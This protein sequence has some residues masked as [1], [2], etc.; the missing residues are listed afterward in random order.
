MLAR[1]T[2][3]PAPPRRINQSVRALLN[4]SP[5]AMYVLSRE[6][7]FGELRLV[8]VNRR[9]AAITGHS[10]QE[11]KAPNWWQR[12][13]HPTDLA[14]VLANLWKLA[15]GEELEMS[16]RFL[17]RDGHFIRVHDRLVGRRQPGGGLELLGAWVDVTDCVAGD[18]AIQPAT[19]ALGHSLC[20]EVFE[21]YPDACVILDGQGRVLEWTH[22]AETLFGVSADQGLGRA[23]D[24]LMQPRGLP[25][26]PTDA[27]ELFLSAAAKRPGGHR[28]RFTIQYQDGTELPV[29]VLVMSVGMD[30]QGRLACFIRDISGQLLNEARMLQAQKLEAIGQ[31]TGGLAHD[32]N[33]ILG[34]VIASLE[35]LSLPYTP[36]EKQQLVAGALSAAGRGVEVIKALLAVARRQTLEPRDVDVNS[37]LWELEPLIRQTVG[38]SIQIKLAPVAMDA[39]AHIDPG[40]FGNAILNLVINARDAMPTGGTLYIY[41][42]RFDLLDNRDNAPEL[43]LGEYIAIG[44]DDTGT[45]MSATVADRAFEPFYTTKDLGKGTGLGLAMVYG[46]ARQSGGTAQI[47]STPGKGTLVTLILPM[48]SRR[49]GLG[50]ADGYDSLKPVPHRP[51]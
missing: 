1:S 36:E 30:G 17:H 19:Q 35:M 33:N 47:Y 20:R 50:L 44:V 41:S 9:L 51:C 48:A 24:S 32:F 13:I 43:A 4:A 18:D 22:R 6:P 3:D 38:E 40:G 2:S 21:S 37:L 49:G 45:G 7:D 25:D 26:E 16:Y 28:R 31:L 34:I 27:F 29:E 46:F 14:E 11:I 12:Q 5:V 23:L 42:H 8:H 10:S 15:R 39:M